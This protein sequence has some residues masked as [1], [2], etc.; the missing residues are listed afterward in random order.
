LLKKIKKKYFSEQNE[1][2]YYFISF[3]RYLQYG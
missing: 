3:I 2:K 1:N